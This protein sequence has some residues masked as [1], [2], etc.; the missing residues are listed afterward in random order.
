MACFVNSIL[1]P[2]RRETLEPSGAEMLVIEARTIPPLLL[3]VCYCPPDDTPALSATMAALG[4]IAAV[5]PGKSLLAVGDFN[6]PEIAWTPTDAGWAALTVT[7][8]TR[9]A[10]TSCS[11]PEE[12]AAGGCVNQ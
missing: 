5:H 3:A 12:P 11:R 8:R 10:A 4:E 6:V 9:P 2:E 1:G 7:C